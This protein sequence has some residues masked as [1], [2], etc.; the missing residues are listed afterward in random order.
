MSSEIDLSAG[1]LVVDV[2]TSPLFLPSKGFKSHRKRTGHLYCLANWQS[3]S[4][5]MVE[6]SLNAVI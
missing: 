5:L 6:K 1:K 2:V 4:S 3:W